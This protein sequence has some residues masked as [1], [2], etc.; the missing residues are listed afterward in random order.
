MSTRWTE[1]QKAEGHIRIAMQRL[2]DR[3]PFHVRILE[4]FAISASPMTTTMSVSPLGNKVSLLY[5][6]EFVLGLPLD[7]LCGVLLHEVHHVLF[8]HLTADP[9]AYPDQW[10]RIVAEEVT[11]NEFVSEPLPGKPI[12][13]ADF[14]KLKPMESTAQRYAQ[15]CSKENQGALAALGATGA[16]GPREAENSAA[17]GPAGM[18]TPVPANSSGGSMPVD[19]RSS[20]PRTDED[21][22]AA[23]SMLRELVQEAAILAGNVPE[24]FQGALRALG[25]GNRPGDKTSVLMPEPRRGLPWTRLLRKYL[26]PVAAQQPDF[27]RPPRRFPDLVGVLPGRRRRFGQP[28]VMA[29]IDTSGSLDDELLSDISSELGWMASD[30][31]VLVV[32]CDVVIHRVYPYK[33][34]ENVVGRGGTDLCPPF[35]PGFLKSHKPDVVVYFTDGFGPAPEKKPRSR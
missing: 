3:Y 33:P 19:D 31:R 21:R 6:T 7:Q 34:I 23:A 14:P 25:I 28:C 20:W 13:L 2:A 32:E 1:S 29:V 4:L 22:A 35:E 16:L 10:A 15:L 17:E 27:Q 24:A 8:G 18:T 12:V 11:V 30:Y 9:A 26:G 5:D